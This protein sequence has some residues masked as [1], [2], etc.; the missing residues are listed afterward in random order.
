MSR[1]LAPSRSISLHL[2]RLFTRYV[3]GI[4]NVHAPGCGAAMQSYGQ[5]FVALLVAAC[6][7]TCTTLGFRLGVHHTGAQI[8]R[9]CCPRQ[10]LCTLARLGLVQLPSRSIPP[11]IRHAQLK[12]THRANSTA[13]TTILSPPTASGSR[14]SVSSPSSCDA[15]RLR[16]PVRCRRRL[17]LSASLSCTQKS[18]LCS[19]SAGISPT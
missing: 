10:V 11:G 2:A 5:G 7:D 4:R 9:A 17:S 1:H 8:H 3:I 12:T 13:A 14:A 19:D 6:S 18:L 15:P 16:V